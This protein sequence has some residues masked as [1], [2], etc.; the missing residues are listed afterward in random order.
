MM[1]AGARDYPKLAAWLDAR[2]ARCMWIAED[3]PGDSQIE[4]WRLGNGR[5]VLI[6]CHGGQSGWDLWTN[7]DSIDIAETLA[8]ADART[9][10]PT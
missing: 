1:A 5:G 7:C 10:G 6:E 2:G 4:A 3:T 8:D 9:G